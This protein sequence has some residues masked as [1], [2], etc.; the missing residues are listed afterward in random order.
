MTPDPPTSPSPTTRPLPVPPGL[1]L[2]DAQQERYSRHILLP[3]FS[4][5]A[6][7]SLLASRVLIIGAGGLGSAVIPYLAAAGVG[8]LTILDADVIEPSNLQRQIL[9]DTASIGRSKAM[10][11][12]ARVAAL[13]PDCHVEPR[14]ERFSLRN[15]VSLVR[16]HDVVVDGSDNFVTRFLSNDT[17]FFET[18]PLCFA[19][20]NQFE[21]MASTFLPGQDSS[22]CYRCLFPEPPPAGLVPSCSEA[23]VLGTTVGMMGMVQASEAIKL[24]AGVG[25]PLVG[26]L[27]LF[28]GLTNRFR[29]VALRR[30]PGCPL[31]GDTPTIHSLREEDTGEGA[32]ACQLP[33]AQ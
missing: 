24:L 21:G 15:A 5:R 18:R 14:I 26:R 22:P 33:P 25:E 16:V 12:A 1:P 11:A 6:Q 10:Q 19:A 31:C 28:D 2:T 9:H 4:G 30:Q 23:G 32:T 3:Q 7:R 20:V 27:L 8:H 29:E 13:N 17:C